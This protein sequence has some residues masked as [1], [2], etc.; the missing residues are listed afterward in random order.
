MK[1][2]INFIWLLSFFLMQSCNAENKPATHNINLSE[3]TPNKQVVET[4]E[5]SK[6]SVSIAAVGDIMLGSG[7]PSEAYLP[8]DCGESLID[9]AVELLQSADI[10]FGNL[11]GAILD[12]GKPAKAGGKNSYAFRMRECAVGVL[13]NAGFDVVNIGNNHSYDFGAAGQNNAM[14]VLDEHKIKY[15]GLELAK[16]AIIEKDGKKIAFIGFANSAHTLRMTDIENA[17]KLVRELK[18]NADIVVVSFHG[19]AEG[20]KYKHV[21]KQTETFLGENRGNPYLFS[22]SLIDAGADLIIGHGPHLPRAAEIYKNRL[23]LYSLGNFCTYKQFGLGG[24]NSFAPV[25]FCTLNENG[26]ISDY[27]IHSFLQEKPGILRKD[28]DNN[29]EKEIFRLSKEDFPESG[30]SR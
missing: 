29:A 16:S 13:A 18:E 7:Y 1:K 6:W 10:T 14:K 23:I 11:E 2:K 25:A 4:K 17:K 9:A 27:K 20:Q 19:G 30:I 28:P 8:P 26:E 24:S 21:T 12:K 15:V 22:H 5:D 3:Q